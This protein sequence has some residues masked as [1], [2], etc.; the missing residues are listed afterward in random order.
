MVS[1]RRFHVRRGCSRNPRDEYHV[2]PAEIRPRY[3]NLEPVVCPID[4]CSH[5]TISMCIYGNTDFVVHCSVAPKL[6]SQD[7]HSGNQVIVQHIHQNQSSKSPY[8]VLPMSNKPN[9][10]QFPY[11][12][13][14]DPVFSRIRRPLVTSRLS[15]NRR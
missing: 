1:F 6:H 9:H 11:S 3:D 5:T 2:L 14:T 10:Q 7:N 15:S 4:C 8:F 13:S 12:F